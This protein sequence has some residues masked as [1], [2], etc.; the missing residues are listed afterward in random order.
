MTMSTQTG[1][2]SDMIKTMSKAFLSEQFLSNDTHAKEG[3]FKTIEL[4]ELFGPIA[5]MYKAIGYMG[6]SRISE[7]EEMH[8]QAKK[9]ARMA[10]NHTVY[11]FIINE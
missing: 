3:Y 8:Q 1:D 11:S 6:L 10:S 7:R 5:D 2:Y 4:A 9:Y